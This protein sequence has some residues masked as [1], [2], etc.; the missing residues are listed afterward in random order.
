MKKLAAILVLALGPLLLAQSATSSSLDRAMKSID[1]ERIRA[2]VKYLSDDA[3]QGR[4]TG[5]KGGDMAADWIA[6]QFKSN[7]LL[8]AGDNGT[9]FQNV[10]FFGV[11]TDAK[12]TQFSFVPNS[13]P[14][15]ALKFADDY[16]A[17]NQRHTEKAAI[18]APIVFVGYGIDAPEYQWNDYKGADLKGKVLLM[19]VNEP[20]SDDPKFF[21][22][23][24]LTYYGRWTY[25]YEEAARRGAIGVMLI[26]KTEMA[27]Y[28]W[29][30]VRNSW[31]GETS[32][33]ADDLDPKLQS[34]GWIQLEVAR[35]LTQAAGRDLDKLMQ[36]ANTRGFQ[37]VELPVRLKATLVSKVRSFAS[38][39]VIGKV[40]GSDAKLKNQAI[41]YTAHYDHFGIHAD[42]PGDNIYNGA[43]DNATGCGIILELAR[44][45]AAAQEKPKRSILFAAVTA[46]EQ[47]LLGSKY[48]GQHPPVPARN[49]SLDLNFD[50]LQPIGEPQEMVATGAD[51]TTVYPFVQKLAKQF[52]LGI[53]PEDRPEAGYYYRSDH[54]SMARV[55]VPAFSINKGALFKGHDRA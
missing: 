21:K 31:G 3:L 2:S 15:I 29:E 39:N 37:P 11:A 34:A 42:E 46:E 49:I 24:A 25:K 17:T 32:L 14:E 33:L 55:G 18:E 23:R 13:G 1:P 28:G 6:E 19:L 50:D 54:F 53:A 36:D 40:A 45:A 47:G 41:L 5:Q 27:S 12:Q 52:D 4:G 8:P 10:N 26:H 44:V 48:L 20:P 35:K 51:R 22:G 43:A 16:V 38:R 30:V 7:G 9:F